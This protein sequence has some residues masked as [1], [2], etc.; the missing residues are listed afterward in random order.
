M[1]EIEKHEVIFFTHNKRK[2]ARFPDCEW[3]RKSKKGHWKQLD[4]HDT[5]L[6][7]NRY[8]A[9]KREMRKNFLKEL[10]FFSGWRPKD[11]DKD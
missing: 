11:K 7:E 2:Y 4:E 5:D 1:M 3:F 9:V 8:R 6:I 10:E